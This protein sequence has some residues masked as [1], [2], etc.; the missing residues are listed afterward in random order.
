MFMVMAYGVPDLL[1]CLLKQSVCIANKGSKLRGSLYN[2]LLWAC[3][4][5]L[6]FFIRKIYHFLC[7]TTFSK[8]HNLFRPKTEFPAMTSSCSG[9][10]ISWQRTWRR[11]PIPVFYHLKS[12]EPLLNEETADH[13]KCNS[14]PDIQ[15]YS[16]RQSDKGR[17]SLF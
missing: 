7:L 17:W 4:L 11:V 10:C 15:N 2:P 9:W 16:A 1:F 8:L 5:L 13:I 3:A 12:K 14:P 6:V